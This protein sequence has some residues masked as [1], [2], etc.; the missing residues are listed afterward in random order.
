MIS[1]VLI[2]FGWGLHYSYGALNCCHEM[3]NR[4]GKYIVCRQ[5]KRD[6]KYREI[7]IRSQSEREREREREREGRKRESS[8]MVAALKISIVSRGI[9][10][11]LSFGFQSF[12]STTVPA[13]LF[14]RII[15]PLWKMNRRREPT[16]ASGWL[17]GSRSWKLISVSQWCVLY[18]IVVYGLRG[19]N[20]A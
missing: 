15:V 12:S 1:F 7:Q 20:R 5:H 8:E 11:F 13:A 19:S 14:G 4:A 3:K 17:R 16:S 2:P 9:D 18:E 6:D 10:R